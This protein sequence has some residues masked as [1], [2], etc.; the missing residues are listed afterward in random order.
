ML[1][2]TSITV[3]LLYWI[4]I[5][6]FTVM[7]RLCPESSFFWFDDGII[8][9]PFDAFSMTFTIIGLFILYEIIVCLKKGQRKKS[10]LFILIFIVLLMSALG[11]S[12]YAHGEFNRHVSGNLEIENSIF[13]KSTYYSDYSYEAEYMVEIEGK[14]LSTV[15]PEDMPDFN[16][17]RHSKL[18]KIGKTRYEVDYEYI[19]KLREEHYQLLKEAVKRNLMKNDDE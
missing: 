7:I 15:L 11:V 5:L 19:E 1:I 2:V 6:Y 17:F 3:S 18:C 12:H 9:N 14:W 10:N 13:L 4:N 8:L 16:D